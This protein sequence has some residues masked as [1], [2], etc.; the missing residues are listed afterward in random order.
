MRDLDSVIRQAAQRKSA[1]AT[2]AEILT[3]LAH[4]TDV[5]GVEAIYVTRRALAGSLGDAKEMVVTHPAWRGRFSGPSY[6][7]DEFSDPK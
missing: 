2:D 6:T 4:E 1:G 5:G 3:W 7:D